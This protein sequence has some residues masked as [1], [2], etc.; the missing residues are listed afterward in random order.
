MICSNTGTAT[1]ARPLRFPALARVALTMLLGFSA[2]AMAHTGNYAFVT[3][4]DEVLA[5][6]SN[7][8]TLLIPGNQDDAASLVADIGFDFALNGTIYSQFSV[9]S[10]GVMALGPAR[11]DAGLPYGPLGQAGKNIVAPFASNQRVHASGR[12]HYRVA[13]TAPSRVLVVE[14]LNMQSGAAAGGQPDLTYQVRLHEGTGEIQFIYGAMTMSAAAAGDVGSARV[15]IG[16]STGNAAGRIGLISAPQSGNPAPSYDGSIASPTGTFYGAG[17]ITVL[18][19]DTLD[20]RRLF[21]FTPPVAVAPSAL[22]FTGTTSTATTLNWTDNSGNELGFAIYRSVDGGANFALLNTV[23]ANA[24]TF[25]DANLF[26]SSRYIY[27]VRAFTEGHVSAPATAEQTS[28]AGATIASQPPGGKWSL[29]A[30]WSGGMVPGPDDNVVITGGSTVTIDGSAEAASVIVGGGVPATLVFDNAAAATLDVASHVTVV[31]SSFLL[32][33]ASGT[34]T[35]HRLRLAGNLVNNGTLDF[36]VVNTAGVTVSFE[37]LLDSTFKGAGTTDLRALE[38]VKHPKAKVTLSPDNF[39]VRGSSTDNNGFLT[40]LTGTLELG[41]TFAGSGRVFPLAAYS[42][43]ANTAFWLNNPNYTVTG[44]A[45]SA[46]LFGTLRVS[47]GIYRVGLGSNTGLLFNPESK[48]VVEG[49]EVIAA[50][51]F[52]VLNTAV[53]FAY[54]QTGGIVTACNVGSVSGSTACFDLGTQAT[55]RIDIRDGTIVLAV[56]N[57][58]GGGPRDYR[59]QAGSG[60]ASIT[61]GT[62]R[63]G[64]AIV[65]AGRTYSVSGVMPNVVVENSHSAFVNTTFVPQIVN[66][67]NGALDIRLISNPSP[68]LPHTLDLGNQLFDFAGRTLINDGILKHDGANSILVFSHPSVPVFYSGSGSVAA[69]LTRIDFQA[70]Q[71]VNF[72]PTSPGL[73]ANSVNLLRGDVRNADRLTVGSGGASTASVTIGAATPTPAGAFDRPLTLNPGSGGLHLSYLRT[74]S[75]RLVGAELGALRSIASLNIDENDP[76]HVL[77]LAGG[78]LEVTGTLGLKNGRFVTGNSTL[79][80]GMATVNRVNGYVDGNLRK[81]VAAAGVRNFEVGSA[82]GYSPVSIDVASGSF[83]AE[84]DVRAIGAPLPPATVAGLMLQRHWTVEGFGLVGDLTFDYLSSDLPPSPP[85]ADL[86]VYRSNAGALEDLGGTIDAVQHRASLAAVPVSADWSL[87]ADGIEGLLDI[88][89]DTVDFQT[90]RVG[91][92][93]APVVVK[94]ANTAVGP[95]TITDLTTASGPFLRSGGNCSAS[96]P[97]VIA[98]NDSCTL[99]YTFCPS[100]SGVANQI[101]TVTTT[102]PGET[103][104]ALGGTGVQ[105]TL[106]IAEGMIDFQDVSLGE[107]SAAATVT[108]TNTGTASLDVTQLA[109]PAAPFARTGGNCSQNMP[110]TLAAGASCTLEYRFTPTALGAANEDLAVVADAPGSGTI[111]LAGNGVAA[112]EG[113]LTITPAFPFGEVVVGQVSGLGIITLGNAGTAPLD[114][115]AITPDAAPF[116]RTADG[117][118]GGLPIRLAAG[119]SCTLTYRFQPTAVGPAQQAFTVTA[120]AP[121]DTAFQLS[122]EGLPAGDAIFADGFE[123]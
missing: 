11:V 2:T 6:M 85:E 28:A 37:G 113:E 12:V 117:S 94:L 57:A 4:T 48:V 18:H 99:E 20:H 91:S 70:D 32:G 59:N 40:L 7:G 92:T 100:R 5:D 66:Y 108:L 46:N 68:P 104:I 103:S 29:P 55:S 35:A 106:S 49:G 96:M 97:I 72:D 43:P 61:G 118:C 50:G 83:P 10:N 62:L 25:T 60:R 86:H 22:P 45:S 26:P 19:S 122:G 44:Q 58:S 23:A 9:N 24:T 77:T 105:G 76:T 75:S 27:D 64:N 95:V 13:G 101:L 17:P 98:G 82:S 107:T 73:I 52:G 34:V 31:G 3:R 1:P 39:T 33:P 65:P 36:S 110:F 121:G 71:G 54:E 21:D 123:N 41:G 119:A 87:A 81:T 53:A 69:P 14:W 30:T 51:Q 42:I 74:L 102:S 120:T 84:L 111:S 67:P 78:D 16:F 89:P 93:S 56:P 15:Q 115:T 112:P 63:L 47:R 8:T 88:N 80:A 109:A 38:V 79:I 90:Q 114:I 116:A